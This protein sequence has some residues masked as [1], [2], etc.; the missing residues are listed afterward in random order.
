MDYP[1]H[2]T[3][4]VMIFITGGTG[5]VGSHLLFE[6]TQKEENIRVLRHSA[7]SVKQVE[8]T[9]SFYTPH[10]KN[11][12]S[13]I[14]WVDGDILDYDFLLS[15]MEGIEKVYHTAAI[16]SF[17][18]AAAAAIMETNLGGTENVVNAC[19]EKKV[20]KLGYVSS[21]AALGRAGNKNITTEETEW[22]QG[23]KTSPYAISKFEAE[24]EVWRGMAEGL[25]VVM[26]NPTI[27]L[28]PGDFQQGSSKIFQTVYKGLKF[29]SGGVNG[30]VDV[31]DV[32]KAIILLMESNISGERFLLNSEN[33][34]YKNLFESIANALG[35]EP[36]KYK[37]GK[38][39]SELG[40]RL[41]KI[42]TLLTGKKPLITS[43]TAHTA[44]SIFRYGN[45]K[46]IK[47]T[48]MQFTPIEKTIKRT[49]EIFLKEQ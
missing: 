35:V 34:S 27:I 25:K 14:E 10:P 9:F 21:V 12:L 3:F 47:A 37:A 36:P 29:Y 24:R 20:K 48:G 33:I 38:F 40:W 15:A 41:L 23:Q 2:T 22:K 30:Y 43:Q 45:E 19:L 5:L 44:N 26:V 18:P 28:G 13:R 16:V 1:F 46:F 32:A 39:A 42:S 11:L 17:D 6:L 4:A 8:R 31:N 7:T 49:A